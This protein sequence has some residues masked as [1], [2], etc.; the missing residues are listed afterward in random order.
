[1]YKT[2]QIKTRGQR[3]YR[4][5]CKQPFAKDSSIMIFPKIF[6]VNTTKT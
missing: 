2:K 1:M 6:A 5:F 4:L 3:D